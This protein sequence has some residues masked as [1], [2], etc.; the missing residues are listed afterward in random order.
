MCA[1]PQSSKNASKFYFLISNNWDFSV[2]N[3]ITLGFNAF[4]P[5]EGES[6]VSSKIPLAKHK[7]FLFR[8]C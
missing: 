2:R 5:S 4:G 3:G 1:T 6:S 7:K 8:V